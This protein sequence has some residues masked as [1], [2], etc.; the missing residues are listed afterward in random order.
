MPNL[1]GLPAAASR[2]SIGPWLFALP[3]TAPANLYSIAFGHFL[4]IHASQPTIAAYR[5]PP[6]LS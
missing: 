6:V 5:A 2:F 1:I 4:T 3:M